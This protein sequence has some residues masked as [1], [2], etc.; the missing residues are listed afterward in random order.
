M[1][2]FAV[3]VFGDNP[4]EKLAPFQENNSGTC[5]PEYLQFFDV[6]KE[7]IKEYKSGKIKVLAQTVDGKQELISLYDDRFR[8]G[9]GFKQ[10]YEYPEDSVKVEV[11]FTAFYPTFESFMRNYKGFT[12]KVDT[13]KLDEEGNPIFKYGYFENANAKWDWYQLGGRWLGYFKLKENSKGAL[14]VPGVFGN[15]AESGRADRV[16]K[17]DINF[18]DEFEEE[19]NSA[20]EFWD[21]V[22]YIVRK[23][24][25]KEFPRGWSYFSELISEK[26]PREA[27]LKEY[28]E[29]DA[30]KALDAAS[31]EIGY[32]L[33]CL[34]DTVYFLEKEEYAE[35]RAWSNVT[36]F[37]FIDLN[38]KWHQ[39]GEMGWFG[40]HSEEVEEQ[41]WATEYWDYFNSL[42][43]NVIVSCYDCH[44]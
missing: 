1:S 12:E 3:V 14:G 7:S 38:G 41:D 32:S 36:P 42:D 37:A 17:G 19:L 31:K 39:K 11:P 9:V 26:Y 24:S 5:P 44:I 34:L 4:E 15:V 43:D 18:K 21:R 16:H 25:S 33:E 27:A 2:H 13:G 23:A 10:V 8:V 22:E 35:K 29:Q 6:E 28:R 20:R 40:C 30:V